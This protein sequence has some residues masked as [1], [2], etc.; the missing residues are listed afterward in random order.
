[1]SCKSHCSCN[2]CHSKKK[3]PNPPP[4][5]PPSALFKF[6]AIITGVT[7]GPTAFPCDLAD[8]GNAECIP[9]GTIAPGLPFPNY[10]AAKPVT[11][12][13]LAVNVQS[14]V[15]VTSPIFDLFFTL[16]R[17]GVP[18]HTPLPYDILAAG[19][20]TVTLN[21]P[22][23]TLAVGQRLTLR[24]SCSQATVPPGAPPIGI[25]AVAQ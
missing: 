4:P 17:D 18:M 10:P 12:S 21:F 16:L 24:C 9:E 6:S 2:S 1:M 23:F 13:S 7:P 22:A 25:S 15:P 19:D 20:N 3:K 5:A 8:A 14:P 11:L